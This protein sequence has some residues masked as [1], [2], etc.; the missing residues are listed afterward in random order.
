MTKAD[1]V[2]ELFAEFGVSLAAPSLYDY[3]KL[4][5]GADRYPVVFPSTTDELARI[6][7][8]ARAQAIPL[9]VRASGHTFNGA[10][11]P[12]EG[13][14]LIRMDRLNHFRFDTPGALTAG[15]GALVWDVRDLAVEHGLNMPVYNGGWAGPT[16]G[17]YINAGGFA[18]GGLSAFFGGLW[19]NVEALT[20]VDGQGEVR[21]V[22]RDHALFPWMFGSYGQLGIIAE[23]RLTMLYS[24]R[25]ATRVYPH[26]LS[27][28]IPARQTDDP[29]LN[30]LAP[31]ERGGST[32]F[33]FSLLVSPADEARAWRDLEALVAAHPDYFV[34]EGG[35]AGPVRDGAPIGYH[36]VIKFRRFNPPLVYPRPE[37]FLVIGVM[38]RLP[39]GDEE[40]NRRL[41]ALEREFIQLAVAGGYRLYL[42]AE[43]FG[44]Q[45]DFRTYYG[46]AVF[47]EFQRW[48]AEC[49]PTGILN[50]GIVF[51][52]A[53]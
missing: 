6:V 29:K 22:D 31:R 35:W 52:S 16:L 36:Y 32:L 19:E 41:L 13:E 37:T 40:S 33:W 42:Q 26:G 3:G 8:I 9:R 53:V 10:S 50:P 23:A 11:L 2:A 21:T 49:D 44:R 45:I 24:S 18:K 38:S 1:R 48:K 5:A 12:R 7:R 47:G 4:Y 25:N 17:G 20:F 28:T 46:D 15:A 43:N 14:L 39:S 51:A 27:G 30:D 34:P